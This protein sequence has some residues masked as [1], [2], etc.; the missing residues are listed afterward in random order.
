NCYDVTL[1]GEGSECYEC[2]VA[3]HSQMNLFA[4]FSVKS[5]DIRYTQHCHNCKHS[6]GC[7]GLRNADYCIFN[8]Q[9]TKEEYEKLVRKIIEHMNSMPYVDA[10]GIEYKYGEYYPVELSIFGYN[11]T[12]APELLPLSKSQALTRGYKW[13]D[14]MQKTT[15][16]E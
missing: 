4:L 14:N 12:Y 7:V 15:G 6:F 16:K 8:K 3:D 13:Q 1:T 11:E 2:T 5:Q 10:Q 9:Y